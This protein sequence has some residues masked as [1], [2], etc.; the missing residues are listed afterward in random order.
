MNADKDNTKYRLTKVEERYQKRKHGTGTSSGYLSRGWCWAM[1]GLYAVYK[2]SQSQVWTIPSFPSTE[3]LR[4]HEMEST[5]EAPGQD[6]TK[7]SATATQGKNQPTHTLH[8]GRTQL[9]RGFFIVSAMRLTYR[10]V[11]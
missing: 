2:I 6:A 8:L 9:Q 11:E 1:I 5:D 3:S 10:I 7:S 4:S